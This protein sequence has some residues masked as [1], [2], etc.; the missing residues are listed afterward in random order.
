MGYHASLHGR[1]AAS[2][3]GGLRLGRSF[4]GG[5]QAGGIPI[6]SP[7]NQGSRPQGGRGSQQAAEAP[8]SLVI[9]GLGDKSLKRLDS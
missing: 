7:G 5:R 4:A 3:P 9:Q 6:G 8:L 2:L 1:A